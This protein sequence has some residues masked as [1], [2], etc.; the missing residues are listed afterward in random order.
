MVRTWVSRAAQDEVIE[1]AF[2]AGTHDDA[3]AAVTS[4]AS[5]L[6]KQGAARQTVA[7]P[8]RFDAYRGSFQ[9]NGAQFAALVLPLARGPYFFLL[10]VYVPAASAASASSL[11]STVATAQ[12]RK[13][14]ADTPDTAP[15]GSD[16]AERAAGASVGTLVGYL[17]IV[18]GIAD[19]RNPL[20]R[21]TLARS[22]RAAP[23]APG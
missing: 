8:A 21:L 23:W 6:A 4:V 10:R 9:D 20:R 19:L 3:Q 1:L 11:M 12:W 13:V 7:G 17:A 14:P 16:L 15:S 5:G 22:S 18:D 2:D